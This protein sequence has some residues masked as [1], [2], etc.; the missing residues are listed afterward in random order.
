MMVFVYGTLANS[1][2]RMSILNRDVP[3]IPSTL[4]GYDGSKK[5]TIENESYFAAEKNTQSVTKGFVIELT[6]EE[7]L[8]LDVYETDAYK[9]REVTLVG[10]MKALVYLNKNSD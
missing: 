5:I 10:G 6:A 9:K 2:I 7:V 4:V 8:K 1:E 3:A